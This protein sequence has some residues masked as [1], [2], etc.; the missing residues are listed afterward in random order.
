MNGQHGYNTY[1]VRPKR[2][3][4]NSWLFHLEDNRP[5][6]AGRLF[7]S[8]LYDSYRLYFMLE[9]KNERNNPF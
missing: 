6:A 9:R 2:S 3:A 4:N 8:E 7:M 1:R 5:V